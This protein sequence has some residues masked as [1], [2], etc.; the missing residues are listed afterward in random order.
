MDESNIPLKTQTEI[1]L[2]VQDLLGK[3]NEKRSK[4]DHKGVVEIINKYIDSTKV[5]SS[6]TGTHNIFTE[7]LEVSNGNKIIQ[8]CLDTYV[9]KYPSEQTDEN[10]DRYAIQ[11][12]FS[13]IVEKK[14]LDKTFH[15]LQQR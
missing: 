2:S 3:I 13:S 7:L 15:N 9:S 11:I 10:D 5:D 14:E 6:S 4:N 12:D 1:S 8:D